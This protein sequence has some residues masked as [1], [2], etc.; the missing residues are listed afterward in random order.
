MIPPRPAA[1]DQPAEEASVVF[2]A[3]AAQPELVAAPRQV[4]PLPPE[5]PVAAA[6]AEPPADV[7]PPALAVEAHAFVSLPQP[8]AHNPACLQYRTAV[9]FYD[10]PAVA[11][12]NAAR[13]DKLVFVLHVAG[14]FEEPGFT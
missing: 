6:V 3:D 9:D 2:A 5:P 13:E 8:A 7:T 10:S 11:S 12:K 14:N 4:I 1:A